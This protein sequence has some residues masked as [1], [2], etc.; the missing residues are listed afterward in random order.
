MF[1]YWAVLAVSSFADDRVI[2]SISSLTSRRLIEGPVPVEGPP[3]DWVDIRDV[4]AILGRGDGARQLSS[5]KLEKCLRDVKDMLAIGMQW[6]DT[7][8]AACELTVDELCDSLL[9]LGEDYE[10]I[11]ERNGELGIVQSVG[12]EPGTMGVTNE[13]VSDSA[14]DELVGS[15]WNL[16][17]IHVAEAW[18]MTRL[19]GRP[20]REVVVAVVDTGVEYDHPDL[21][22]SIFS[23]A[24]C[25]H[26]YNFF[27]SDLDPRDVNGHGTHCAG[28]LGATTNNAQGVAGI[29]PVKIMS[30][31]AFDE[32]GKGDLLYSLQAV[33]YLVTLRVE[34]SSHS[35]T[36]DG[37]YRTLE[38]AMKRA[39]DRGHLM[40]AAAGNDGRDITIART[41]PCAYSETVELLMCVGATDIYARDRLARESNYGRYVDIAAPGVGIP[42]TY[43]GNVYAYMSGTSMATPHVAGVAA[44]L[45]SLGVGPSDIKEVLLE[46]SDTVYYP[47]GNRVGNFGKV[48]AAKA[49][50]L[51]LTKPTVRPNGERS[52]PGREC[53]EIRS[54]AKQQ[55]FIMV[56]FLLPLIVASHL[57]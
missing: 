51:A 46:S 41:Y 38:A 40:F 28:I 43:I 52:R 4:P 7:A 35:Y 16:D 10:V 19:E 1:F 53:I 5:D 14:D 39:S 31:R 21:V 24:D 9:G 57:Y 34:V 22:D 8:V 48:N 17:E 27:D 50:E 15:Q 18:K 54:G 23:D 33:N 42:S 55:S 32:M 29:A 36:S 2:V 37:T 11:C 44:L 13:V 25:R 56:A 3:P 26:G 12:F 49:V 30:L 20:R 6:I 45:S 47:G